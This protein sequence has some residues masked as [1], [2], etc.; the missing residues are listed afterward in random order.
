MKHHD[1]IFILLFLY[2]REQFIFDRSG[3]SM[4]SHILN[5]SLDVPENSVD[6]KIHLDI[7]T[8]SASSVPPITFEF[9][10]RALSGIID[11]KPIGIVFKK[12]A[13]IT[14]RHSVIE[15]PLLSS[16]GVKFYNHEKKAWIILP[17]DAGRHRYIC[18]T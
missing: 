1:L 18:H 3:G 8:T 11:M 4:K 12:A 2:R 16:I 5:V 6:S 13:T 10:E 9:G 15:L 17:R 14:V 7:G